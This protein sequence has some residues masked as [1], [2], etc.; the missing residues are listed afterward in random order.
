MLNFTINKNLAVIGSIYFPQPMG[1]GVKYY[2]IYNQ[3]PKT[4]ERKFNEIINQ[5]ENNEL[6]GIIFYLAT[7]LFL[8]ISSENYY[9]I[10]K[11]IM[12]YLNKVKTLVI[13]FEENIFEN[14]DYYD[15]EQE[16]FLT[17]KELQ[18]LILSTQL[19][20]D[21]QI[22]KI[23]SNTKIRQ[24][25]EEDFIKF[26]NLSNYDEDFFDYGLEERIFKLQ[27]SL[28]RIIYSRENSDQIS[29]FIE[30][31]L[32]SNINLT[33]FKEKKEI[34]YR[35]ETFIEEVV[36]D[37]FFSIYVP[38]EQMFADE[39]NDFLKIFEKYLQ[40]IENINFTID[41]QTSMKGTRYYF[42]SKN[43]NFNLNEFSPAVKRFNDFIELCT[44][45]PDSA[46]ELLKN[47]FQD[48]TYALQLIQTFVKKFKRL[49]MDLK[50][51]HQQLELLLKQDIENAVIE[52]E[53]DGNANLLFRDT[54][55]IKNSFNILKND[56]GMTYSKFHQ[57]YS[58]EDLIIL[59]IA[60]EFGEQNEIIM[61]KS[62]IE[63]LKD[64]E[65]SLSERK[66]AIDKIKVF[67]IKAGKKTLKHAEDIT[68][69]VLT[70]YLENLT[71]GI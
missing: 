71:K 39:F 56:S 70:S 3:K 51:Q 31:L 15:Y 57:N 23:K 58:K 46:L 42:K 60:K 5:I 33:T 59:E 24:N 30:D 7:P 25:I 1:V 62:N 22:E 64:A 9:P 54:N 47:K 32:K 13:A 18:E 6:D 38:N 21:S 52:M 45:N 67:L 17:E 16:K 8:Q 37:I 2:N 19:K 41:S 49:S 20:L 63:I 10:W 4:W 29:I 11:K 48:S 43:K 28:D 14:F 44:I 35:I 12:P 66:T 26:Q 27:K 65:V 69:K 68:V 36:K 61:V 55:L 34:G 40:Q 53:I 50:H